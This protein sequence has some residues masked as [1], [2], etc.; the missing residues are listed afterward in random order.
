MTSINQK[1]FQF[2]LRRP[3]REDFERAVFERKGVRFDQVPLP[4]SLEFV[5]EIL[6]LMP[7]E[8]RRF[9]THKA[10][11]RI[12]SSGIILEALPPIPDKLS[13]DLD[14]LI[15]DNPDTVAQ[16]RRQIESVQED[17]RPLEINE[18]IRRVMVCFLLAKDG[19]IGRGRNRSYNVI[20]N[21]GNNGSY[22][23]RRIARDRPDILDRMKAGEFKS[24]RA[25][26]REAGLI[27][28]EYFSVPL[29]PEGAA[30]TIKRRNMGTWL[31][32]ISSNSGWTE[33]TDGRLN[34]LV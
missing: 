22:L 15:E 2:N 7:E 24:V 32:S 26:A 28:T 17:R 25:A 33:C 18:H 19:E 23:T 9:C 8:V 10:I 4:V 30:R 29:D 11:D 34:S 14:L 6:L 31:V 21:Y 12:S 3:T 13:D 16:L 5:S 1:K 20:P 27:K